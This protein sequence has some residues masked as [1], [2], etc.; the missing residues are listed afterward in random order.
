MPNPL[1]DS[2]FAPHIGKETPFLLLEDADDLTHGAFLR[3]AG[4]Y[5]HALVAMGLAPGDRLAVR[6]EKSPEALAVFAACV[7]AGVVFLPLNTGYAHREVAYFL[8]DSGAKAV[9]GRSDELGEL[10]RDC[11]RLGV[12]FETLEADGTGSFPEAA[13]AMPTEFNAV[14]CGPDDL[15]ALLYTSGTTGLS[16]GAMLT[17]RNLLSNAQAL[18]DYWRFTA[19]DVL[20]HAL[21]IFHTHGLFVATNVCLLAGSSMIFLPRFNLNA[22]MSAL[23]RATTMMGVPTFYTRLLDHP[24]F[25]REF[26]A[27]M[28]LFISGSAP[29][30]PE[31]FHDFEARTGHQI[32]ERYGLTETGMNTSNPCMGE[33]R[34]GSIGLALPGVELRITDPD[35]GKAKAADEIG[36]IEV[37]GENV[38]AGYWR[39]P[40][41]TAQELRPDGFFITGDIGTMSEDG[42]VTI[43]GRG[44]DLIIA[45][46]FNIYPRDVE[47]VLDAQP[48]VLESAVIGAPHRDLGEGVVAILVPEPGVKLDVLTIEAE[49]SGKI[50]RFKQPRHYVIIEELPRNSMGKVQKNL[51]RQTYQDVF[52][53]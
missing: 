3:V 10:R 8:K 39:L 46:G 15:A 42:Y 37:R 50:A 2:L 14:D 24:K 4:R 28:R 7:M 53:V 29:L 23:P 20:I 35:T 27:G 40:E 11:D 43:V 33:R 30:L 26:C 17:H 47:L 34:A 16:K 51:L 38:F 12:R 25:T 48:G 31:T 52:A 45:G 13:M 22:V 19:G 36:M 6:V 1:Y 32:L 21:P 9:L 49:I 41:K 18:T 5:A 44:K